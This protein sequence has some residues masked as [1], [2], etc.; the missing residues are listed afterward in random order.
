MRI[1]VTGANGFIGQHLVTRLEKLSQVPLTLFQRK[2]GS[3][4]QIKDYKNFVKGLDL[5]YH[6]GGINRADDEAILRGNV[7]ATANLLTA[8]Q[9]FALPTTRIVFASSTQVYRM[10]GAKKKLS[11]RCSVES[12]TIYGISKRVAE[13]L[14]RV[15]GLPHIILRLS[16]AYGPGCQPDYN[17]VIATFCHRAV[18]GETLKIN[19]DG[20]Q[21]RDFIYID[22]VVEAFIV[23]GFANK[24]SGTFNV[25]AGKISSLKKVIE[26]ISK[27]GIPVKVNY[28][29]ELDAGGDSYC[30]DASRFEKTFDWKASTPLLTGIRK[31]LSPLQNQASL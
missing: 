4:P 22:D 2:P 10:T 23:A 31:T 15:S 9:Q 16:N 3:V 18:S 28:H 8:I 20:S 30:C 12:E 1:G 19:G 6:L 14:I 24:P 7:L 11:E 13:D 26:K 5:I 17:S 29:P 25:G 21:G 27:A